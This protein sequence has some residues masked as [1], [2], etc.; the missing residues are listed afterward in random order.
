[1]AHTQHRWQFWLDT[2]SIL[3]K[4]GGAA[5]LYAAPLFLQTWLQ[6]DPQ[7]REPW[8]II[9]E[10]EADRLRLQRLLKD[11]LGRVQERVYF[12]YSELN[13][14]GQIQMGELAA[15]KDLADLG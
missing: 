10:N 9:Q 11:L 5:T 1:M 4:K 12:C 6:T 8:T 3:W 15:L 7:N 13:T 14:S 2:G